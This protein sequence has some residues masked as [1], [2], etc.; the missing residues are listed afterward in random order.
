MFNL[1]WTVTCHLPKKEE[2]HLSI[3][4]TQLR[5]LCTSKRRLHPDAFWHSLFTALLHGTSESS[6]IKK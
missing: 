1:H 5:T 6:A 4:V 2:N 3:S